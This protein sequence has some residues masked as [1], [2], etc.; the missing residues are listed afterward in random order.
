MNTPR[1][2]LILLCLLFGTIALPQ[3]SAQNGPT[4]TPILQALRI[5]PR[6]RKSTWDGILDEAAWELATPAREFTQS[7][8]DFGAVATER[9]ILKIIYDESNL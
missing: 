9:T 6:R 3:A 7:D 2:S 4:D 5:R 1:P 8:P